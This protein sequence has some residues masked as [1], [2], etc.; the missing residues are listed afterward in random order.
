MRVYVWLIAPRHPADGGGRRWSSRSSARSPTPPR[1]RSRCC[2][3]P[4]R[5]AP[6]APDMGTEREV[7]TSGVRRRRRGGAARHLALG[8]A[9]RASTVSV[10]ADTAVLVIDYTAPSAEAAYDGAD[11]FTRSYVD[12]RNAEQKV[13]VAS[14]ITSPGAPEAGG[15]TRLRADRRRRPAGRPRAGAR[16]RPGSGTGSRTGCA[17]RASSSGPARRWS[18]SARQPALGRRRHR[19]GTA[20]DFAFL[21]GRLSSMTGGRREGVRILVT[22]PRRRSGASTVAINTAAALA[23][24]GRRVVLVDADLVLAAAAARSSRAAPTRAS[25]RC[26]PAAA[27][28]EEALRTTLAAGRAAA[29]GRRHRSPSAGSTSTA[30]SSR[31]GQLAA[32]DIVVVDAPAL[33]DL[34]GDR[35]SSPTTSTSSLLVADLQ[36]AAASRRRRDPAAARRGRRRVT[37]AWVTHP[38]YGSRGA[39]AAGPAQGLHR[40]RRR[41]VDRGAD[42]RPRRGVGRLRH[43]HAGPR[44]AADQGRAAAAGGARRGAARRR[45]REARERPCDRGSTDRPP[46]RPGTSPRCRPARWRGAAR[47]PHLRAAG[48][49]GRCGSRDPTTAGPNHRM[50]DARR[51]RAALRDAAAGRCTAPTRRAGTAGCCHRVTG[52]FTGTTDEIIQWAACKWGLSDNLL[53]AIAVRESGWYQYEVYPDG[54]C[55]SRQR[56]RRPLRRRPTPRQPRASARMANRFTRAVAAYP[57][58]SLSRRRSPSSG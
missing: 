54:T 23:G 53:R 7:A 19:A 38:P 34:A 31:L 42:A 15:S 39:R 24:L 46:P 37:L 41:P 10:V 25:R 17:A 32:R 40:R 12:A 36:H 29:A 3:S 14:V 33:L 22:A 50:P 35:W 57:S 9:V 2:R 18:S 44:H 55:V 43:E 28:V 5:G 52:H 1:P 26:W 47:R 21:A 20:E 11:A 13:R 4:T 56:V 27:G 16:A 49:T 30:C 6:I 48:C 45:R 8:G 51:V 58:R